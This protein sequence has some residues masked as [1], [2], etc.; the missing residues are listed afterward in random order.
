VLL[1][2]MTGLLEAKGV[3]TFAID[4]LGVG[5]TDFDLPRERAVELYESG[6]AAAEEFLSHERAL[7]PLPAR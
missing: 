2:W 3:R 1:Q 5:T 4:S 7:P 6:R